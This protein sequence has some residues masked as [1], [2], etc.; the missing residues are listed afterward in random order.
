MGRHRKGKTRSPG[1]SVIAA[2]S[3]VTAGLSSGSSGPPASDSAKTVSARAPAAIPR[4]IRVERRIAPITP[5][6]PTPA[7][8]VP[9]SVPTPPR[10]IP[11]AIPQ[12]Q[13]SVPKP[14]GPSHALLSPGSPA[15]HT[16]GSLLSPAGRA[17]V[18]S[19]AKSLSGTPYRWGGRSTAG[20]DC[21]GLVYLVLKRAGLS[22]QYRTSDALRD[23]T[24]PVSRSAALPGDLVFGPG[25]V[26]I[27]A[28]G[29]MMIDAPDYGQEVGLRRVYDNMTSYGRL[30][31]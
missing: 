12:R 16:A 31:V 9:E 27:Y 3:A 18:V 8:V 25:H 7:R 15:G 29:G 13:Y 5:A 28:G 20:V 1:K 30:P 2:V 17:E 10:P 4:A 6:A 14:S 21:S 26:G 23:W 19:V 24:R 11:S 22:S